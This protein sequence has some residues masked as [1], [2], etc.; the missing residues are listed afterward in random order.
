MTLHITVVWSPGPRQVQEVPLELPF[1]A[2]VQDALLNAG[3]AIGD[4]A[5][6]EVGIWGRKCALNTPLREADRVECYRPLL[7]DP[8]VAR[9]ARF[10]KQGARTAGLFARRRDGSKAGY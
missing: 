6:M 4:L 1:G 9:K 7:V 5:A 8:K 10:G 3:H 2:T